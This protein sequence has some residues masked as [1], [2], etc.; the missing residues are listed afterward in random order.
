MLIAVEFYDD[1]RLNA[2]EVDNSWTNCM[3]TAETMAAELF[4]AN[5]RPQLAF[6]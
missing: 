4:V 5:A 2:G 3:L 6:R 1:A